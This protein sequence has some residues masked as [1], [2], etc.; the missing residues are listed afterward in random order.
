MDINEIIDWLGTRD[1]IV[2]AEPVKFIA[3]LRDRFKD[4]DA[5]GVF[6]N[7]VKRYNNMLREKYTQEGSGNHLLVI[8]TDGEKVSTVWGGSIHGLAGAYASIAVNDEDYVELMQETTTAM[9]INSIHKR[10][11]NDDTD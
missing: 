8:A 10:L 2:I 1:D 9:L 3:D 7:D 5:T 6:L 4:P 11:N